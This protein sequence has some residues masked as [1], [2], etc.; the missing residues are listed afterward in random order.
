MTE[1]LNPDEADV[2]LNFGAPHIAY[3]KS[4]EARGGWTPSYY[5]V[6]DADFYAVPPVRVAYDGR[7]AEFMR[8]LEDR[9]PA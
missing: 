9:Y 4:V 2:L 7:R 8:Y 3:L 5:V 1:T 6:P